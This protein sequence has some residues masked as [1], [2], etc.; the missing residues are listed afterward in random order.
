MNFIL[1]KWYIHKNT[2]FDEFL[3][4]TKVP[5][6]QRKIAKHSNIDLEIKKINDTT[7]IKN[8]NSLFYKND[9]KIILDGNYH[10]NHTVTRKYNI[11]EGENTTITVDVQGSIVNWK[12]KI[13]F[14]DPHLIVEYIWNVKNENK[15]ARQYFLRY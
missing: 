7:F 3:K 4:F 10:K 8:I 11:E 15:Y 9:E 1:G 14:N 2:D 13:Y 5:W 6:Y 12:E